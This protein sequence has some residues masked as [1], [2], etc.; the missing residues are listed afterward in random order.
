VKYEVKK[1]RNKEVTEV[2]HE[3]KKEKTIKV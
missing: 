1:E 3:I 2:K